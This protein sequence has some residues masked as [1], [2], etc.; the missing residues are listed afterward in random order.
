MRLRTPAI[1]LLLCLPLAAFA[2]SAAPPPNLGRQA[3][4]PEARYFRVIALVHLVGTGTLDDPIR[5]EYVPNDHGMKAPAPALS[6]LAA[7]KP[8]ALRP[9]ILGWSMLPTDDKK[10]A[11]VHLVAADRHAFDALLS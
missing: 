4:S 8:G 9:G 1:S 6:A 5:P 7:A 3:A 11:I 10:M 2:Q